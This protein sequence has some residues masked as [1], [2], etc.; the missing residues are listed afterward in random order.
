MVFLWLTRI[1]SLFDFKISHE[2]DSYESTIL[3]RLRI[4][5]LAS[6]R[7]NVH[8]QFEDWYGSAFQWMWLLYSW[9]MW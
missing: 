5:V 9:L 8:M 4:I 7:C 3:I 1:R 6:R 2:F